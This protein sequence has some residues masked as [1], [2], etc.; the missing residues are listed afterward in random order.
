MKPYRRFAAACIDCIFWV[1]YKTLA[2]YGTLNFTI[3]ISSLLIAS[4]ITAK[5]SKKRKLQLK[6]KAPRCNVNAPKYKI[7]KST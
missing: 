1:G 6:K 7:I 3:L 2:A 5:R 4:M